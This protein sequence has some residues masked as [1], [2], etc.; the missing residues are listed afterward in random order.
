[1]RAFVDHCK[2]GFGSEQIA[3]LNVVQPGAVGQS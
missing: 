2:S 3:G 1:V